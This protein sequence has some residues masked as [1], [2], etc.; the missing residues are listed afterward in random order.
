MLA[1][2]SLCRPG[3]PQNQKSACLC[4]PSA[5]SKGVHHHHPALI[6][7]HKRETQPMALLTF[8]GKTGIAIWSLFSLR[9]AYIVKADLQYSPCPSLHPCVCVCV[10]VCVCIH[11]RTLHFLPLPHSTGIIGYEASL[12]PAWVTWSFEEKELRENTPLSY[13]HS[14]SQVEKLLNKSLR[15]NVSVEVY[16]SQW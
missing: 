16:I 13:K 5:G 12:R 1:W 15:R 7:K 10:C 4:L 3:W 14:Y 9:Q 8:V 11:P 2:N 6:C